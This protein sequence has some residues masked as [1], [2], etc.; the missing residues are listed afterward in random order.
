MLG[1]K[2]NNKFFLIIQLIDKKNE[3]LFSTN[4]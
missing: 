1:I 2:K 4:I 3:D